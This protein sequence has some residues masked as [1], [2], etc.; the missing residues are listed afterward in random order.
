MGEDF[1]DTHQ[2]AEYLDLFMTLEIKQDR[3]DGGPL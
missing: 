3:L 1:W 2:G